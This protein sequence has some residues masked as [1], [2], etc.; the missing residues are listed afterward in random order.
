MFSILR[1]L[2]ILRVLRLVT[3]LPRLRVIVETIIRSLPNIGWISCLMLINF[4]IFAVLVTTIFG[5]D[6]PEWFG[7]IG[8]SMY[9]M[10][11]ITTM[12]SWSS[13]IVRP[14]MEQY[15]YAYLLFIPFVLISTFIILNTFIGV[16]VSTVSEV[17]A[18]HNELDMTKDSSKTQELNLAEELASIHKKLDN[19][20][21]RL[22]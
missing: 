7:S 18:K 16:I 1:A 20:E 11:Q 17:A 9:T 21:K 19:I 3:N 12:D 8:S 14:L 10:F 22:A 13:G 4:Y 5:T 6:F 15:P 2:R